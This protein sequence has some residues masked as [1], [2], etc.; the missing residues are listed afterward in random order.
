VINFVNFIFALFT[1]PLG[2]YQLLHTLKESPLNWNLP[3]SKRFVKV[4]LVMLKFKRLR[5]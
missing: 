3:W 2:D 1:P 4:R 5:I